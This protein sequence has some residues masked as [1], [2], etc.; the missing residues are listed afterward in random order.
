MSNIIWKFAVHGSALIGAI[1]YGRQIAFGPYAITGLMFVAPVLVMLIIYCAF[2]ALGHSG[3]VASLRVFGDLTKGGT[4][5]C[6]GVLLALAVL[7]SPSSAA[8]EQGVQL[9]A[10]LVCTAILA[11]IV[12]IIVWMVKTI[13]RL[14]IWLFSSNSKNGSDDTNKLNG[15]SSLAV[16]FVVLGVMSLEGTPFGFAFAPEGEVTAQIEIAAK[17]EAVW[18]AINVASSPQLELPLLLSMLPHPVS[19]VDEGGAAGSKRTVHF[20]GREGEGDMVLVAQPRNGNSQMWQVTSDTS[21]LAMWAKMQSVTY[22][23]EATQTGIRLTVT[24][25][26]SRQLSPAWFFK[27]YMNLV[28]GQAASVLARDKHDRA[29]IGEGA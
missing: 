23:V 19:I 17:P 6:G 7:P 18:K 5:L 24:A 22:A 9:A 11:I 28:V 15:F 29:L 3:R 25:A 21:P 12:F 14:L 16:V 26:Y 20:A 2:D 1:V 10:F 27:P 13:F 8:G 4:I